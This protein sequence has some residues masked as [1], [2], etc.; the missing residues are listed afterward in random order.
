LGDD[1]DG[2]SGMRD[3]VPLRTAPRTSVGGSA[4]LAPRWRGEAGLR[5]PHRRG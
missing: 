5:P 4:G 1:A 3:R 2:F